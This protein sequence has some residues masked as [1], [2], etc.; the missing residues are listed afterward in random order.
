VSHLPAARDAESGAPTRL[1]EDGKSLARP[2]HL[3]LHMSGKGPGGQIGI[4]QRFGI[5]LYAA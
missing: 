2:L 5:M 4:W 1:A 3:K